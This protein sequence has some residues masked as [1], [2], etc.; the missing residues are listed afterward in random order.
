MQSVPAFFQLRSW[1]TEGRM[2]AA[3]ET[4]KGAHMVR[5]RPLEREDLPAEHR[6]IY[7]DAEA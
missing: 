5:L 1:G 7:D 4:W 6:R 2:L 3:L